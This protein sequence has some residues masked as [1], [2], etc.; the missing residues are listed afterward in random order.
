MFNAG[1]DLLTRPAGSIGTS[2]L[3][4]PYGAI[5]TATGFNQEG[6][7]G[8]IIDYILVLDIGAAL[9]SN[10]NPTNN[11]KAPRWAITRY[12]VINNQFY[13]GQY[14]FRVSDHNMVT[15]VFNRLESGTS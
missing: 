8:K 9:P 6:G 1:D 15:A 2:L 13:D 14:P 11:G 7:K 4:K 5:G 3:S 10:S 12:G